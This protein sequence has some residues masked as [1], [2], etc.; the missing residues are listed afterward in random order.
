M[1][2]ALMKS[3]KDPMQICYA[4][5]LLLPSF[6]PRKEFEKGQQTQILLNELIHKV[7]HDYKF[8]RNT[9]KNIIEAD[10][11]TAKLFDIYQTVYLEGFAQ[12]IS[13][14]L[15]RSDYMLN[16]DDVNKLKQIEIN[17]IS[18]SFGGLA[19]ITSAYQ[20]FILSELGYRE[21]ISSIP[22][23][24]AA[25]GFCKGLVEAWKLYNN[26]KAMILVVVEDIVYNI[27]DQRA[28]EFRIQK[29]NPEIVISRRT[30]TELIKQA[31]LGP[32]KQLLV[33]NSEVA[34]VYYRSGYQLEAYPT[35]KEWKVRLLI[36]RS[37]AI[38][39]PSIH[40]H[41]A[42]T[43]KVQQQLAVP[44]VL[45]NYFT[46]SNELA[47]IR[48]L[49]VDIYSLDLDEM[50]DIAVEKAL[51]DPNKYVL[52]PQREGGGYNIYGQEIKA[53]L[54]AMKNSIDR[55]AW[56]LMERIHPP[57][58]KNYLIRH[59][60][61]CLELQELVSELGIYGVIMGNQNEIIMNTQ[62]G[63]ILRTKPSSVNE[64]GIIVGA[65]ALDCPYLID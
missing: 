21:A 54:E 62:C 37:K 27:F 23:N 52:K 48:E 59:D 25:N 13:L 8:L 44:G 18:T 45:E 56:I 1:H 22:L 9:L 58:Q 61:E 49:F 12:S 39:C 29:T 4:P 14:G 3:K 41:L 40:Y 28:L 43:K 19:P 26:K 32:Q 2:G 11:F 63:H 53:K 31:S 38:K 55:T 65:G 57:I 6:F 51:K 15:V 17:M 33:N 24:E 10:D 36:E 35:E 47:R 64:G 50:G 60:D 34:V 16:T 42:G 46:D 7:A 20:R 30:M 5:F